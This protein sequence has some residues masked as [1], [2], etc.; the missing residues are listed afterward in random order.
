MTDFK[1]TPSQT[2]GPYFAYGLTPTQYGYD[3]KSLF[4]PVLAQPHTPGES[5]RLTGR[6]LDAAG[7]PIHDAMIEISQVDAAGR[8]PANAAEVAATGFRGF[9]RMGT[10]T[11]AGNRFE[12]VTVKPAATGD[13]Q[14]PHINLIVMMRGLLS[15]AFTRV[16]F[17]D[18]QAAN[19]A[20]PVLADVAPD[21]R[22]TLIACREEQP[23]GVVY[24]FDIR[25]QGPDET[26]FFDV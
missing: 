4:G 23:G 21:R 20:D 11:L 17:S 18:E 10:G 9:G 8:Y 1:Q 16:Y 22:S 3:L 13:G 19:D 15:H 25:M 24:H 12:F 2:V 7:N 6:V 14:A 26:V 5:I